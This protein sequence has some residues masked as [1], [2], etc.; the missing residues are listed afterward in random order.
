MGFLK[1]VQQTNGGDQFLGGARHDRKTAEL[2]TGGM[3]GYM[4]LLGDKTGGS[5]KIFDN[6]ASNGAYMEGHVIPIVIRT[7]EF[8][9]LFE[10]VQTGLGA[11]YRK[12]WIEIF[13]THAE[14]ING[15]DTSYKVSTESHAAGA[16][17][18]QQE[19]YT[20]VEINQSNITYEILEK[21]G[22]PVHK[23]LRFLIRFSMMDPMTRYA[24]L[25]TIPQIRE[26]MKGVIYP[27]TFYTGALM[28]AELDI[29]GINVEKAFYAINF[30]PKGDGDVTGKADKA[31]SGR[32]MKKYSI[33]CSSMVIENEVTAAHAQAIIDQMSIFNLVPEDAPLPLSK[34]DVSLSL[35]ADGQ[36]NYGREA[37]ENIDN[38]PESGQK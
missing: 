10:L 30:F 38:I 37:L 28:F 29:L 5:Q 21:L 17:N 33:E 34:D 18:L 6:W 23:F 26:N 24:L 13:T 3:F 2:S 7:P 22:R 8:F 25:G 12:L 14:T 1:E 31:N 15:L 11:K 16:S 32:E 4:P 19:E 27:P 36:N 35:S 9:E 20:N